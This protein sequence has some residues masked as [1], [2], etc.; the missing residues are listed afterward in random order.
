MEPP[1]L[2][3]LTVRLSP[4]Y[5]PRGRICNFWSLFGW[6]IMGF[7]SRLFARFLIW[8]AVLPIAS[9]ARHSYTGNYSRSHIQKTLWQSKSSQIPLK[10]T[11]LQ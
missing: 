8:S 1:S 5:Y 11:R 3:I 4:G 2:T 6:S 7:L 9:T 10:F